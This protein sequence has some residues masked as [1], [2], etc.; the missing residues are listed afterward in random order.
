VLGTVS[1]ITGTFKEVNEILPSICYNVRRLM[2]EEKKKQFYTLSVHSYAN[3]HYEKGNIFM[4][5][6]DY[7]NSIKEFQEAVK[8]DKN[9]V[10]AIDHLAVSYRRQ[11]NY[12]KAIKYYQRS[13]DIFPEGDLALLNIAAAYLLLKDY[14]YSLKYYSKLIFFYPESPEGYYGAAKVYF[15]KSDFENALDNVFT[16][17]RIYIETN[18]DYTEDSKQ[19]IGIM[20]SKLKELNRIDIFNTQAEKNNVTINVE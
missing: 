20:Y 11:E 1:G 5:K 14:D 17:H 16:A 19:L 12:K 15:I 4:D 18:S 10:Y 13:L 3:E 9:F 6:G 8:L 7:S 2:I